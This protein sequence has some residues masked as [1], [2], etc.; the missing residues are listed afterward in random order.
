VTGVFE[1]YSALVTG[2][3]RGIGR[4][5]AARLVAEGA[6]VVL[7]DIDESSVVRAAVE[8]GDRATA[9]VAD[10]T[11]RADV[12]RAVEIA[13]P[14][15][16]LDILVSNVG[17]ALETPFD[18]LDD[19]D[20]SYQLSASLTG[21]FLTAQIASRALVQSPRGGRAVLI[22]SVNGM[23]GFG[24]E[25]YSAAKAAVHNLA[26]NLAVRF[27]SSGVRFNTVAPGTVVTEA[28]GPRVDADP[29]LLDRLS[30][31]YPLRSLGAP[32][33]VA[34]AA[35]FLLSDEA[36]WITG[37][38]LVVD[39]GLTAGNLALARDRDI[40]ADAEGSGP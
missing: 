35:A 5:I 20:W 29:G 3:G 23:S 24:H 14:S 21:S 33:D 2:A 17:V 9:V 8:L 25:A 7:V 13:A 34:S 18:E 30:A 11:S 4:A 28:W 15:G 6:S 32:E 31:H 19:D 38:L 39:G 16:A 26:R 22:G 1:G 37:A 12:T 10:V 36:R 40:S 27:G